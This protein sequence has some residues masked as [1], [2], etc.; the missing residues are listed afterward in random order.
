MSRAGT[1]RI[2]ALAAAY[3]SSNRPR[4]IEAFLEGLPDAS[5]VLDADGRITHCN[6][7][8]DRLSGYTCTDLLRMTLRQLLACEPPEGLEALRQRVLDSG[9][10]TACHAEL[11]APHGAHTP[12]E[13]SLCLLNPGDI[14]R[15]L[16]L[17]VARSSASGVDPCFKMLVA[18]SGE[19]LLAYDLE[20]RLIYA[21]P[22][23]ERLTGLSH[24]ELEL[25][26]I[27]QWVHPD[28]RDRMLALYESLFTGGSFE[29][30]E[31][32][33]LD[34]EGHVKWVAASWGQLSEDAG[35]QVGV[36]GRERDIT[37]RKLAEIA[38]RDSARH[39]TQAEAHYRTLFEESPVPMWEEDFSQVHALLDEHVPAAAGDW[40]AYL[41]R[42]PDLVAE[43]VRRIR[44]L[45]INR[46]AR[47]FYGAGSREEII[48]GF[49]T[50]FDAAA[51]SVFGQELATFASGRSLHQA[52]FEV[53]TLRG[54]TRSV[55]MFVSLESGH[56]GD[57]SRVI[58]AFLDVTE[59]QRLN[60][61]FLQAQKMESLGRLAGGVAHD[62]NNL[63][64]VINGYSDILLAHLPPGDPA[65]DWAAE[66]RKAGQTG[67]AL[68]AQLLSFSR[69]RPPRPASLCLND[70]LRE[71]EPMV[72]TMVG[73]DI[74]CVFLLDAS[75][76][77]VQG[78]AEMLRQL[79]LH[80]VAN[81][82]EAM[83]KGGVLT[84]ATRLASP[85]GRPH[86]VLQVADT[87]AGMDEEVR[88]HLFEPFF[89]TKRARIGG[90]LGL[91]SV[92]G[93]VHQQGGHIDV[94]SEPGKGSTFTIHLPASSQLPVAEPSPTPS[95]YARDTVL[96]A[97]D[98]PDV[99]SLCRAI[100]ESQGFRVLAAAN[101]AEALAISASH[102]GPILLL[103]T[104]IVMPG[105]NGLELA[106][107]FTSSRPGTPVIYMSGYTDGELD[108]SGR[109]AEGAAFLTKPFAPDALTAM[110]RRV[111]G[112][113]RG[114]ERA[115]AAGGGI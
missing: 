69:R 44:I 47:E 23:A 92:L 10:P 7:L 105:M 75:A 98:Q 48:R 53:R 56:I 21:N 11:L 60:E 93:L 1:H 95:P 107:R 13:L 25:A 112:R 89:T 86:I 9:Q 59:T 20:R 30:E 32:R 17:C 65:R 111:L 31:Y 67:A 76:G 66:I 87:G 101:G 90:G 57:W 51:C 68:I 91:T 79:V 14:E 41:D 64:T 103:L 46:S 114:G 82:K 100:L 83:P 106:D 5:W 109:L 45:D 29:E 73:E 49:E 58:A 81:A 2:K 72:R 110:V 36:Q 54:Q 84:L 71:M 63:L 12:V 80:L 26:P 78:D 88:R 85:Q 33:L 115:F 43:C 74:G 6:H 19:M 77:F 3:Q 94:A 102:G 39:L 62:F 70:L 34:G 8:A 27:G 52:S 42:N 16:L 37:A 104:D 24:E 18:N 99:R 50:L 96:L 40:H 35:R 97:E 61:E 55:R 113:E 4:R 38:L 28:D 22:A 108:G 15:P